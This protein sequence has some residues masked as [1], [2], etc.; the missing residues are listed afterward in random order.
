MVRGDRQGACWLVALIATLVLA[1]CG[2]G[3]S[4]SSR[5][6]FWS[7]AVGPDDVIS[8]QVS[9]GGGTLWLPLKWGSVP[10]ET[11]ELAAYIGRF[12]YKTV[13]GEKKLVAQFGALVSGIDPGL[14]GIAAN[15]FPPEVVP[16]SVGLTSCPVVR[17]GQNILLGLFALDTGWVAPTSLDTSFIARLTEEAVGVERPKASSESAARLTEKALAAGWVTAIYGPK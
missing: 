9:C 1:G 8:P 17:K 11:N 10:D 2:E 3:S 14:H 7:P 5:I 13:D 15:T 4:D 12:K 16:V 6:D